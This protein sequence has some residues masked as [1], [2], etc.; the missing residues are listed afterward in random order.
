VFDST[1]LLN[2]ILD[3]VL[4]FLP[5]EPAASKRLDDIGEAEPDGMQEPQSLESVNPE[6]G[7]HLKSGATAPAATT[8]RAAS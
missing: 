6:S 3:H 1:R 5:T 4:Q 2:T 7:V 8:I